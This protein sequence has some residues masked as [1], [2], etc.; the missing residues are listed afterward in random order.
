MDQEL[1]GAADSSGPSGDSPLHPLPDRAEKWNPPRTLWKATTT[2][3]SP[4]KIS[5]MTR[6]FP[7]HDSGERS[8]YPTVVIVTALKY[9][10][11][12]ALAQSPWHDLKRSP[13]QYDSA[14]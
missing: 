3:M 9:N 2:R 14:G 8:P 4:T 6:S 11:S 5:R 10:A 12:R 13:D 7:S 1:F